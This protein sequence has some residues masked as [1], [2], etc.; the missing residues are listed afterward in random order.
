MQK[1]K[2][3]TFN[4]NGNDLRRVMYY[5]G[6]QDDD[7]IVC[8]FHDDNRPSCHVNYDEGVFHCFACESSGNAFQFVQLANPNINGLNQLRLYFTILNSKKVSKLKLHT[9]KRKGKLKHRKTVDKQEELIIAQ[10]YYFGL[11]T[12]N[13]KKIDNT[14]KDYMLQRGFNAKALNLCKAKQ[15]MTD[16]NYPIVF[17]IY[18]MDQFKGFVRRTQNKYFE[19]QANKYLYNKGFSRLDTLGG[20][21]DSEVVV[22]VEG[23]MDWLKLRM[24]GLEHV[25]AIFGWKITTKQL[26]KLRARGVKTVISA[27]DMDGPGIRGTDYLRNF[28]EVI[29]FQFP[30]GVK[31]PGDLNEKQFKIAYKKTKALYRRGRTN[32]VN[33]K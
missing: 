1:K 27:L 2:P 8:P 5:Y 17:P 15:T 12:E 28:F 29:Q 25:A 6:I 23:Y 19:T 13:W 7:Q 22:L 32:N 9:S 31:D 11:R 21:Y 3:I 26:D 16:E 4:P 20:R 33:S 14:Y 30:K 18:D 10:D 24:F